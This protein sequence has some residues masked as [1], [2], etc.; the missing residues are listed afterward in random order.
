MS[1][2]AGNPEGGTPSSGL[3]GVPEGYV[4]R[5]ELETTEAKRRGLQSE[6][7]RLKA[8]LAKAT[9]TP[10][11]PAPQQATFDEAAF[12]EKLFARM[13]QRE[14]IRDA[15][16]GLSQELPFARPE[17]LSADYQT[18]EELRAAVERSHTEVKSFRDQVAEESRASVIAELKE[19]HGIDVPAPQAAPSDGEGGP[20]EPS[21][22]DLA[23]MPFSDFLN[24]DQ[25]V[26][27]KA[28]AS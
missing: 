22:R 4:P 6:N 24:V 23:A 2:P 12:T 19:K 10:A 28:V 26:I 14:A 3:P 18:P 9:A 5:S 17:V 8:E 21:A 1:E 7:D 11:A 16:A 20:Q 15:R 27:D 13:A 25:A